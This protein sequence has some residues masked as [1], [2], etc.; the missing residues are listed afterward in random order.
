MNELIGNRQENNFTICYKSIASSNFLVD[1]LLTGLLIADF[2][3][4]LLMPAPEDKD[5]ANK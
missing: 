3:F 2:C 4:R 5:I 1:L